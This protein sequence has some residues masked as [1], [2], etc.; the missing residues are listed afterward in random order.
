[1]IRRL[2]DKKSETKAPSNIFNLPQNIYEEALKYPKNLSF[3]HFVR[4][5]VAPTMCFQLVYP[6]TK[7]IRVTFIL[8][9]LIE[10]IG[11]NLLIM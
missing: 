1:M 6:S 3:K 4:Y 2:K 9:R 7:Q 8:K 5:M 11:G 10:V